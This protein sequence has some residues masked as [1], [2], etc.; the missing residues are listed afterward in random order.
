MDEYEYTPAR[1]K[2]ERDVL[3]E[4]MRKIAECGMGK[5][6]PGTLDSSVYTWYTR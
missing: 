2:E 4:D 3:G 6:I 1:H 5:F